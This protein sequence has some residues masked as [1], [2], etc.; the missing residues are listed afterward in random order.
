M[1][2]IGCNTGVYKDCGNCKLCACAAIPKEKAQGRTGTLFKWRKQVLNIGFDPFFSRDQLRSPKLPKVL[3]HPNRFIFSSS[4]LCNDDSA[5]QWGGIG[6]Q[7]ECDAKQAMSAFLIDDA[8]VY[9]RGGG[10]GDLDR[11]RP[12]RRL[13][14]LP[15]GWY[16]SS[17]LRWSI[18]QGETSDS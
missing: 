9:M 5:E 16:G 14:C 11:R 7:V 15:C 3:L 1:F 17:W 18:G 6:K 2:D 10:L 8:E 12:K 13:H 4:D